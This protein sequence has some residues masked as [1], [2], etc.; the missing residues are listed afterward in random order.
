MDEV[1]EKRIFSSKK[2]KQIFLFALISSSYALCRFM[3]KDSE[4]YLHLHQSYWFFTMKIELY[5]NSFSNHRIRALEKRNDT[6]WYSL[7]EIS[8]PYEFTT[9]F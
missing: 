7:V 4:S 9:Y 1:A 3:V 5:S 2:G 6:K 8:F